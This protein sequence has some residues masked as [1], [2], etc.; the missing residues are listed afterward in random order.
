MRSY[1]AIDRIEGKYAVCEVELVDVDTSKIVE[2]KDKPTKRVYFLVESITNC[3]GT[4][5]EN[6]ILIVEQECGTILVIY[7]KDDEEK[8]RRLQ[9][10][11]V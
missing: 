8:Q 5:K 2:A 11:K 1:V 7:K 9:E 4:C 10:Y 3:I 6:D